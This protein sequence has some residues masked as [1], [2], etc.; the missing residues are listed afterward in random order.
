M[1]HELH[2]LARILLDHGWSGTDYLR[3]VAARHQARG[4]GV[5]PIDRKRVSRW[6][7]RSTTPEWT[8]QLAMADL[9]H[10]PVRHL[11]DHPWPAWP[12]C[13]G[14][15]DAALLDPAW[16]T[17]HTIEILDKTAGGPMDRRD[18]L[19]IGALGAIT[20]QWTGAS[21]AEAAAHGRGR[22]VG[23]AVADLHDTR[24]QA[25]R[26]LD[27]QVGSGEVHTAARTELRMITDTLTRASY[28]HDTGRRLYAAAA[29]AARICGWTAY[30]SSPGN[31]RESRPA[32][33]ARIP[34]WFSWTVIEPSD[35]HRV[36]R[37]PSPSRR[38]APRGGRVR[39][40]CARGKRLDGPRDR[41]W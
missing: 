2:P 4:F 32:A 1:E 20:A 17:A 41:P 36:R 18:F 26:L 22:R 40:G 15:D 21:P 6:I 30:D 31:P 39:P 16:C 38:T 29:E 23:T 5:M 34:L 24:L 3:R 25:L 27:D 7:N 28:T 13:V 11:Y 9:H 10:V 33:P 19:V 14:H 8:A 35:H 37:G 12:A